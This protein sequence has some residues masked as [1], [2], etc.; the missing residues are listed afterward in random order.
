[1]TQNQVMGVLRAVIPALLAY[2]V[3]RH[4]IT[5]SVAG[6]IGAAIIAGGAAWWSAATNQEDK[7][8]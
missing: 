8:K 6:E 7:P 4:W 3:G 5:E 2:A 1:M